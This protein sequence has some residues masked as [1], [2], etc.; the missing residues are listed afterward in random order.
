MTFSVNSEISVHEGDT[1]NLALSMSQAEI[2]DLI[3]VCHE[4]LESKL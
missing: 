2:L 4:A 1:L 3:R